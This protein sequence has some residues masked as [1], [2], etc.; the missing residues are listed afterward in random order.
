MKTVR[1]PQMR[2]D[3][4]DALR[5]LSARNY[6]DREWGV[7]QADINRYDDLTLNI[8]LLYDDCRVLPDPSVQV[9]TVLLPS[10]VAPLRALQAEL[11]PLLDDLGDRPDSAYLKDP[12]WARVVAAAGVAL[13]ALEQNWFIAG[14]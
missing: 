13:R 4:V 5:S 7:Y 12:R 6:Q 10:D 11:A 8:H 2:D 14:S 9:G 3:V 1:Y